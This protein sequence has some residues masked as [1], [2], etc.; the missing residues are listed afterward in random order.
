MATFL[1]DLA[2]AIRIAIR[3]PALTVVTVFTLALGIGG[4]SAIFSMVN[5]LFLRP[6]PVER[7][8]RTG[9]SLRRR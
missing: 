8:E 1:N 5:S 6:L 2:Y 4:S 7:P 3:R 9:A